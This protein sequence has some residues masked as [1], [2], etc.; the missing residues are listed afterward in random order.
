[1]HRHSGKRPGGQAAVRQDLQAAL[2]PGVASADRV[3][4]HLLRLLVRDYVLVVLVPGGRYRV[5]DHGAGRL[6]NVVS[7][8]DLHFFHFLVDIQMKHLLR[9]V[10]KHVTSGGTEDIVVRVGMLQSIVPTL[11]LLSKGVMTS[12]HV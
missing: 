4:H 1:M 8:S 5:A 12:V 9:L 7:C 10:G 11:L 6:R 3:H 2:V